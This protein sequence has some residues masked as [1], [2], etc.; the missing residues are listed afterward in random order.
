VGGD[1]ITTSMTLGVVMVVE[2]GV[3]TVANKIFLVL[4]ENLAIPVG[5]K[6]VSWSD[7][8]QDWFFIED[9]VWFISLDTIWDGATG[10]PDGKEDPNKPGYPVLWKASLIHDLGYMFMEHEDFPYSRKEIDAIFLELMKDADFRCAFLYY[11]GVRSFG[12]AWNQLSM[13]YRVVLNTER[14][15]PS[16]LS[17]YTRSEILVIP[18]EEN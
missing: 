18:T 7:S 4:D 9:G 8:T 3:A 15:L 16:H 5:K 13:W 17:V 6:I 14:Q 2:T 11:L 1:I 12:G 10:V